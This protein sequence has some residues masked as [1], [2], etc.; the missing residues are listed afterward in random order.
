MVHYDHHWTI[1]LEGGESSELNWMFVFVCLSV[2]LSVSCDSSDD[3]QLNIKFRWKKD[4][5]SNNE[6]TRY[7]CMVD[8]GY[9]SK[10]NS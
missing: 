7:V 10:Y 6:S 1:K 3:I 2:C 9:I 4:E 8:N 5:P